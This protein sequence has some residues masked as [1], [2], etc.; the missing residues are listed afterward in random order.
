MTGAAPIIDVDVTTQ[1]P[2]PGA[3]DYARR[4]IGAL[5]KFIDQPDCHAR[6][7]LTN[8]T[9]GHHPRPVVAQANLELA[10][11]RIRAQVEAPSVPEAVDALQDRLRRI[12]EGQPS[13]RRSR[14]AADR[15]AGHHGLPAIP[16]WPNPSP[17]ADSAQI[18]RRKSFSVAHLSVD[19]AAEEMALLDYHFHLFTEK[20]TGVAGVL[21]RSGSTGYRLAQVV[22]PSRE[23]LAP[24]DLPLTISPHSAPCLTLTEA[25]ERIGLLGLPFLFFIDAAEGRAEVLYH[26]YDGHYGLI[27]P[28]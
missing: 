16:Q 19:Q 6:V 13:R 23:Q 24:F 1:G 9:R 5:A 22:P 3:A 12:L 27:T 28:A 7:R 10:G 26:R 14:H 2:L 15:A 20:A 8:H 11:R 25:T 4:K 17:A 18:L 21:Y